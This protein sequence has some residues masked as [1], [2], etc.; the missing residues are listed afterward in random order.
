[1]DTH[2]Q[3]IKL[4]SQMILPQ[5]DQLLVFYKYNVP[6]ELFCCS[7]AAQFNEK[8][9]LEI[10]SVGDEWFIQALGLNNNTIKIL[11]NCNLPILGTILQYF[12]LAAICGNSCS[13]F[14]GVL[15]S[16]RTCNK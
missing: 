8:Q 14:R 13:Y 5:L 1:M 3:L 4:F 12:E 16:T 9:G 11:K 6:T 7:S 10:F 2:L 15:F